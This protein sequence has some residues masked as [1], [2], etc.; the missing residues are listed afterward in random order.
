[1][2]MVDKIN[3]FIA[4]E[5]QGA[6]HQVV[7]EKGCCHVVKT[8]LWVLSIG[9]T[10]TIA[11]G[12]FTAAAL[13]LA[14]V[15]ALSVPAVVTLLAVGTVASI[16]TIA[17]A[18]LFCRSSNPSEIKQ[19]EILD[20]PKS[21]LPKLSLDSDEAK[22][23]S[24]PILPII[25]KSNDY[26][27]RELEPSGLDLDK[28]NT[29]ADTTHQKIFA[30]KKNEKFMFQYNIKKTDDADLFRASLMAL[31][32]DKKCQA[33]EVVEGSEERKGYILMY[34]YGLEEKALK[35]NVKPDETIILYTEETAKEYFRKM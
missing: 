34:S 30:V 24:S 19:E 5:V 21:T 13:A 6:N 18:I 7:E 10:A 31:A 32:R 35:Q 29:N 17:L 23:F 8:A 9:V 25:P 27:V 11:A 20:S 1:M 4:T 2:S 12:S 3:P 14:G 15:I 16:A 22:P 28:I 26:K 33:F